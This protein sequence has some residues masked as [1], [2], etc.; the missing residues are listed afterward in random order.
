[1]LTSKKTYGGKK[2]LFSSKENVF[3]LLKESFDLK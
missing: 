1:M 3:I 2:P